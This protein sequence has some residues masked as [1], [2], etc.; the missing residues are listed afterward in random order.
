MLWIKEQELEMMRRWGIS[1]EN[2][3]LFGKPTI[4]ENEVITYKDLKSRELIAGSGVVEQGDA[5]LRY[6]YNKLSIRTIETIL[7]NMQLLSN[8]QG[9]SEVAVQGGQQF[10]WD[11][12]RLMRD[13]FKMNPMPL[14]ISKGDV[15][16]GVRSNFNR[17]DIGGVSM[18]ASWN[19][20]IDAPWRA[21]DT[22]AFG[23]SKRSKEAYFFAMG[24]IMDNPNIELVALGNGG[25]DR[26]FVKREIDGMTSIRSNNSSNAANSVDGAQCQILSETGVKL[27][28]EWGIGV[29]RSA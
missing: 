22:D 11:F 12:D 21:G 24:T 4:D 15:E 14:F 5:S 17:Y 29:L 2:Q 10:I 3:L 25:E 16:R 27:E 28:N 8:N 23:V 7:Q 6:T 18:I 13:V 1:R 26:A 19:Q 9:M 20:S